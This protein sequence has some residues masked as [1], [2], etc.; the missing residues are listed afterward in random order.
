MKWKLIA[1][2]VL[3]LTISFAAQK[4][5]NA[6]LAGAR[7]VASDAIV[8]AQAAFDYADSVEAQAEVRV[9]AAEA[10]A[11]RRAVAAP[12]RAAIVEAAPDTCDAAIAALQAEVAEADSTAADY[13]AAFE[14]EKQAAARLRAG[15][16]T[17]VEATDDLVKAS[18]GFWKSITPKFG[19]GA[20]AIYD[21]I[22]GRVAA[23]PGITLT[24]SF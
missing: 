7:R 5:H 16:E 2:A 4:Y 22:Q 6:Q 21:P 1:G 15:A 10:R 24:W 19:I 14:D 3:F 20:A 17:V 23:G 8:E 13:K 9:N 11:A 18:G 12:A